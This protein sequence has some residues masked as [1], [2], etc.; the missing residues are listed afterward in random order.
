MNTTVTRWCA[1]YGLSEIAK[2]NTKAQKELILRI[3]EIVKK[4]KN[5]KI[6]VGI[7]QICVIRVLF[8]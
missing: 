3:K 2:H 7:R 8:Q 1:A 4:E 6:S 5:N